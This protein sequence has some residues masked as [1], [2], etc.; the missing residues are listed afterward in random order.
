MRNATRALWLLL[1]VALAVRLAA[2]VRL[3]ES[4]IT[5]Y[6]ESGVTA[7]N[8]V[9]GRGYTFDFYGRRPD[10]PLQAFMPP[11]YPLLIS[12]V[13]A[14]APNPPFAL[15]AIQAILSALAVPL[16]FYLAWELSG[17]AIAGW[18]SALAIAF[19]P[20][21]VVMSAKPA[22][23]TLNMFLLLAL[24]AGAVLWQ[25]RLTS[26][27]ALI[28]GTALGIN[29]LTRPAL[30]GF[31]PILLLG[32]A[33]NNPGRFVPVL[34]SWGLVTA[35]A[36]LIVLPWLVRNAQVL[37]EFGVMATNGGLTFW[38]GNN[39]F[40]TGSA[41]N[42][43]TEREDQYLGRPHVPD[44]PTIVSD[45]NYPMPPSVAAR[46]ATIPETELDRALYR[47]GFEFWLSNPTDALHLFFTKLVAFWWFRQNVG[48]IYDPAWTAAYQVVYVGLLALCIPGFLLS[49]RTWRRYV[50]LYLLLAYATLTYVVYNVL[51]RYR[52]EVEPYLLVF[53]SLA[54]AAGLRRLAPQ[55]QQVLDARN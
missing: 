21:F 55:S 29:L 20:V 1:A 11:L 14:F 39:P 9:S 12:S 3:G 19:Y 37:G 41:F 46:L 34:K 17:Q 53:A 6:T 25:K 38:N 40:T 44:S 26:R 15:E 2:V 24:L 52:W 28:T 42:V 31:L 8:L 23:T 54:V 18:L 10:H 16:A 13:L 51:M 48:E 36:A 22:Q 33:L 35:L 4:E 30:I 47:A 50:L 7:Q 45:F 49:L 5:G 43:Y 32:A 27:A